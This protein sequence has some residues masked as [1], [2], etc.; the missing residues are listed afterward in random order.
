MAEVNVLPIYPTFREML[1]EDKGL[2]E[3]ALRV[4]EP[5]ISEFT[6]TNLFVWRESHQIQLSRLRNNILVKRWNPGFEKFFLLPPI[7]NEKLEDVVETMQSLA[8]NKS[9]LPIYGLDRQHV[10]SL[11]ETDFTVKEIRDSWD[12]V[13]LV[14]DLVDLPGEKYY[15][16]RKNIEKCVTEYKPE[17]ESLTKERVADCLEL[18]TN[19]CNLKN[20]S[21]NP[22]L[23]SENKA[24]R[25]L[26]L[27][28]DDLNVFG[29]IV[30]VQGS[31]KAFIIGERLN[32]NT[33][34][35]HFEKANH[36][37]DGLYQVINQRFCLNALQDFKYVNREQDLGIPGLRQ[38]KMSYHPN[39]FIEK[40]LVT[41]VEGV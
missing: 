32:N 4:Y 34:V 3:D 35:I 26:F 30:M 18:Q 31:V 25:E 40:Y 17:Y 27:H 9:L 39:F 33:A 36:N 21:A 37:I 41:P 2:I 12:Y 24:I 6:F 7:G 19:W 38:A 23:E 16:K 5:K 14:K 13:Y 22:G 28:F 8:D 15:V 10:T 1:F 11:K 20:C 29:G